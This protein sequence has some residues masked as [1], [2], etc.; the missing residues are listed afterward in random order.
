MALEYPWPA[1][2]GRRIRAGGWWR[3]RAA[4][5]GRLALR[6]GDGVG[7]GRADPRVAAADAGAGDAGAMA[8]SAPTDRSGFEAFFREH[9]RAVFSY[10]YRMTGDEQAAYDLSQETFV[11]AWQRYDQ[12]RGYELP[13]AWLLRVATN[14]ALNHQRDGA[15]PVRAA[16]SLDSGLDPAGSDPFWR[17]AEA[18][19]MRGAIREALLAMP[20]R[21]RAALVLREVYGLSGEEVAGA[22]GISHAA[23]K[24]LLSR[25][26]EQFRIRYRGKEEPR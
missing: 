7:R 4:A 2:A 23:A 6:L 24:M 25:A 15:S 16:L 26:R 22:L 8:G 18:D 3:I 12:I 21:Q 17:F 20:A 11:R 5:L 9:E 1:H 19:A 13:A 10:L 14:L